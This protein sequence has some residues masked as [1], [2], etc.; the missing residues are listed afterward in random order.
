MN[1]RVLISALVCASGAASA[2]PELT[3]GPYLQLAGPTGITIVFR[4]ATLST[5]EVRFGEVGR[6]LGLRVTEVVPTTEHVM[7]LTGLL[8]QTSYDYEVVV[9]GVPLAG[10]D[11]FRFRTYPAPGTS[12]P[13]RFFAWGDSGTGTNAQLQVAERL[14]RDSD[15]ADLSL[16]LGDIIYYVGEPELYDARFFGPYASLLRRMVV[17][18][19]IG[20]HDVGLD[21]LGGPYLDAFYLPTNNPAGSE[22]YYSFDYGDAHFVCL[23]TH[24]SGYQP[25][26]PQLLWAAADLAA[27][28]AK[29]KFV[30]FHVPPYSGGTHADNPFIRDAI[31]PVLE[32]AGVDVVFSGHSH[33]YERTYLLRGNTITQGDRASYV[34][35]VPDAGTLYVV[36]GTAG[37]SGSLSRPQHPLMAF[38]A[39]NVLGAS[40]IDVNGDD[41]H[42][43]FLK[44]DGDA[45]DLFRIRKGPDT[46]PPRIVTVRSVTPT[47]LE[48]V[49]DEPVFEGA[50]FGGA[51]RLGAWDLKPFV[52]LFS[53]RLAADGRTVV[54]ETGPMAP[55]AYVVGA[56]GIGDRSGRGNLSAAHFP[57]DV[58][59]RLELS[60][61]QGARFV[62]GDAGSDWRDALA[63]E[64]GWTSGTLPIGYGESG[65]TTT[66]GPPLT[67]LYVRV[68]FTLPVYRTY[69]RRL[70]LELDYDDGFVASLNGV[71]V[72]RQNVGA[73]QGPDTLASADRER[74]LTQRYL[75]APR[76]DVLLRDD[77]NVLAIEVHNSSGA[78]S[79]LYL[80][81]RLTAEI[82][83]PPDAG[84]PD[85]GGDGGADDA[86]IDAGADAGFDASVEAPDAGTDAGS[87]QP[88]DG[89]GPMSPDAG[90]PMLGGGGCTCDAAAGSGW[91]LVVALWWAR[92]RARRSTR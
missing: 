30:F 69:V 37:Q 54:L 86:G 89:G 3:R 46:A 72:A 60:V 87:Q 33:V 66:L 38:Q 15:E 35:D 2:A 64:T 74:G 26:A 34:R 50:G 53:A 18:P 9:D 10:G 28:N 77:T 68:P 62:V 57:F 23:D 65:L 22:L 1:A 76:A 6:A 43:Y 12:A 63:D 5:G 78:S 56:L 67:T 92:R 49:F 13:F 82:D 81:L 59:R 91:V 16:I 70:E 7:H 52:R 17:W 31:L 41:L 85:A 84:A 47:R 83:E 79:D 73:S 51:E 40:V 11:A 24:V 21:P 88:V 61:G 36:S 19:T 25:G 27:S 71:E 4:T 29:W 45:I 20:N 58:R 8:P 44:D 14:A 80:S 75:V 48:V 55:G 32:A 90:Q 39:G 42:G